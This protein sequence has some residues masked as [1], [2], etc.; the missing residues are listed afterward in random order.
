MSKKDINEHLN[1][2]VENI[3]SNTL[4]KALNEM[5]DFK[6]KSHFQSLASHLTSI[7]KNVFND[8]ESYFAVL[9]EYR[10]NY[11]VNGIYDVVA[12]DIFV[13]SGSQDFINI[14]CDDEE[15]ERILDDLFRRLNLANVL[16]SITP[17]LLHYGSYALVPVVDDV[18]GV[19][20]ILDKYEPK[21]VI[22]VSDGK[23]LPLVYYIIEGLTPKGNPYSTVDGLSAAPITRADNKKYKYM[24]ISEIIYFSLDLGYQRLELPKDFMDKIPAKG[25]DVVDSIV[26]ATLKL[27]SPQS[28]IWPAIDKLKETL[29]LDKL[30]VLRDVGSVLTPNMV[31]VPVPDLY[32]PE[33]LINLTQRYDDLLNNNV[34]KINN[35]N[36]DITLQELASVKVIPI[37]GERSRLENIDIGRGE[38][39]SN[40][41]S[42]DNSLQKTL[43]TL[44]IPLELFNGDS[45]FETNSKTNARYAKKIKRIQ[46]NIV[47]SLKMLCL[48]HLS[49]V[50]P[51]EVFYEEDIRISLKNNVN[52]DELEN[53]EAQDL[54]LASVSNLSNLLDTI[55]GLVENSS[56]EIDYDE[57]VENIQESFKVLGSKYH[58][59]FKKIEEDAELEA[60][61]RQDMNDPLLD[62]ESDSTRNMKSEE[63]LN[64]N[65]EKDI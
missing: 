12:N 59:V 58:T 42:L 46:K 30:N 16:L 36:L 64:N 54:M 25:K 41:E 44:G 52:I 29:L 55:S 48:L 35:N 39:I 8:R 63:S 57:V 21:N 14:N 6:H 60:E 19:I 32:D 3:V 65:K 26:P 56:Y 33:E 18:K 17:D 4:S 7:L 40:P 49:V 37:V 34:V 47:R 51:D 1:Q 38:P 45:D 23:N 22:C 28:F 27:K 31:G 62:D 9:D 20:D 5:T 50:R 43:N 13:D 2:K 53:M 11:I 61:I 24:S 10:N 15:V